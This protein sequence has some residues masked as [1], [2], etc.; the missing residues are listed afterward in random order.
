MSGL[1]KCAIKTLKQSETVANHSIGIVQHSIHIVTHFER[2]TDLLAWIGF[3]PLRPSLVLNEFEGDPS[4]S[5]ELREM[6]ASHDVMSLREVNAD[7]REQTRL[8]TSTTE[9]VQQ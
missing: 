3:G 8:Y 7:G 9:H 6:S 2:D 5:Q 1:S 4:F